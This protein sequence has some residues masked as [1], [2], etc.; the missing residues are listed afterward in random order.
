MKHWMQMLITAGLVAFTASAAWA[1][2]GVQLNAVVEKE[3]RTVTE[4]GVE[5]VRRVPADKVIPGDRVIYTIK[6]ANIG[7]QGAGNVQI[8]D[9][10]PE[11]MTYV[12]GSANGENARVLYSVDGGQH[13]D[14]PENLKVM[15]ER[16]EPRPARGTDYTHIRWTLLEDLEPG[17]SASV[18][19]QAQLQ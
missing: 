5:E 10:I 7:D 17:A 11:H 16:G 3:V 6:A 15:D 8:N 12:E 19:F 13:Y 14:R 18:W 1:Q 9:P 2:G 4:A